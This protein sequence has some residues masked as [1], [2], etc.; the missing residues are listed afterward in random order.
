MM[1]RNPNMLLMEFFETVYR[2]MRLLAASGGTLQQY[3][4]AIHA[5]EKQ[6]SRPPLVGDLSCTTVTRFIEHERKRGMAAATIN[7]RLRHLL[8]L[9]RLVR[10]RGFFDA[11]LDELRLLR[12]KQAAPSA[13]TETEMESLIASCRLARG[14]F[15]GVPAA[16]WWESLVLLIY[17]TGLRRS[18]AMQVRFDEIDFTTGMLRV[19]AERMKNGVEQ[20]FKLHTQTIQAILSTLPPRRKLVFPWPFY[21]QACLYGRFRVILRRAGLPFGSKDMF[22]KIRRTTASHT[23]RLL[24]ESIASMQLGHQDGS[25]IKRYIDPRFTARHDAADVLPRPGWVNPREI[26]VTLHRESP[27]AGEPETV[28]YSHADLRGDGDDVFSRLAETEDMSPRDIKAALDALGMRAKELA[29]EI[30]LTPWSLARMLRGKRPL[31]ADLASR[32]R[33]AL[34]ISF[35]REGEAGAARRDGAA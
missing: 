6:L 10:K 9:A 11:D 1:E 29:E 20:F 21:H 34:G 27:T 7:A 16:A 12:E 33:G 2:P 32:I 24:G 30:G 19:P 17:D 25:T 3:R 35:N 15:L 26:T 23:A 18:P 31:S 22:H 28:E 14:R 5:V 13:W 4:I 8:A